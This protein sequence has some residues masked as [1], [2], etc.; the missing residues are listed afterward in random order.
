MF[1]PQVGSLFQQI[2]ERI[3][4]HIFSNL[5][6]CTIHTNSQSIGAC[7]IAGVGLLVYLVKQITSLQVEHH[8]ADGRWEQ[9]LCKGWLSLPEASREP[10]GSTDALLATR[11]VKAAAC[12]HGLFGW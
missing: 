10:G 4:N 1:V 8:Y 3:Q 9:G 5:S 6:Q 11:R 2:V 12:R 7:D